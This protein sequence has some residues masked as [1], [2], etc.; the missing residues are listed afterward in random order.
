[1]DIDIP[2]FQPDW[3]WASMSNNPWFSYKGWRGIVY[4][5]HTRVGYRWVLSY[6]SRKA[7][8][9]CFSPTSYSEQGAAMAAVVEALQAKL[10]G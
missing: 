8:Q 2:A 10:N 6:G 3:H 1:M 5:N 4:A 9:P 7:V